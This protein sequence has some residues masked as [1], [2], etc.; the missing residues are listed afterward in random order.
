MTRD[1]VAAYLLT[2]LSWPGV[3]GEKDTM[4]DA[5]ERWHDTPGLSFV[6]AFLAAWALVTNRPV[7][8]KNVAELQGQGVDV[9]QP[10]PVE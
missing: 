6:D 2:V 8:T 4:V 9:P 1:D 3:V 7:Y 5:V 10:L